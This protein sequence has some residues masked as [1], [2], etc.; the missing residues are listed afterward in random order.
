MNM[1]FDDD[2]FARKELGE[3]L[4]RYVEDNHMLYDEALVLSL[5]GKFGSGKTCF[6]KMWQQLLEDKKHTVIYINA[7]QSDFMDSPIVPITGEL[8]QQL[9]NLGPKEKKLQ[10]LG[11][12]ITR[13]S[14]SISAQLI[15]RYTGIDP[16]QVGKE[17]QNEP[18]EDIVATYIK[19]QEKLNEL[20]KLLSQIVESQ[21]EKPFIILVDEL[22]RARPDYSVH[23]LEAIKHIFSVNGIC[24]VLAVDRKRM[25]QSVEK[26]F[27]KIDFDNYYRRF[28]SREFSL[29]LIDANHFGSFFYEIGKKYPD[30]IN[31]NFIKNFNSDFEITVEI[32]ELTPREVEHVCHYFLQFF[33]KNS[34]KQIYYFWLLATLFLIVINIKDCDNLY[35]KIGT[36]EITTE[37]LGEELKKYKFRSAMKYEPLKWDLWVNKIIASHLDKK[38]D[39]DQAEKVY[40]NIK[41]GNA[42]D[43]HILQSLKEMGGGFISDDRLFS[44]VYKR[45]QKLQFFLDQ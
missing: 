14:I 41:Y 19:Q 18:Q 2:L 25:E 23:F 1:T 38:S 31:K 3:N 9:K 16:Q 4:M 24:F 7:W 5:N 33:N 15:H 45:M 22:D 34:A 10:T 37:E 44:G 42:S 28:V 17:S 26:L 12:T 21:P 39:L 13:G 43:D 40:N 27:G 32:L 11:N 29:P 35:H 6:L 20:R 30:I 8:I 36:G